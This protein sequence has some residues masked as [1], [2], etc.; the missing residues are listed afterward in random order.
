[1][2]DIDIDGLTDEQLD[3]LSARLKARDKELGDRP[4]VCESGA[5]GIEWR[6]GYAGA[7]YPELCGKCGGRGYVDHRSA[8]QSEPWDAVAALSAVAEALRRD[9]HFAV[10]SPS[11]GVWKA[12]RGEA[13]ATF[14]HAD[15]GVAD[16]ELVSGRA[17]AAKT[18]TVHGTGPLVMT[19]DKV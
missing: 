7:D 6:S 13:T 9:F 15:A 19:I 14:R 1:M 2:A 17:G 16:Y 8:P 10:T 12:V 3:R 11:T 5:S 4:V 18:S